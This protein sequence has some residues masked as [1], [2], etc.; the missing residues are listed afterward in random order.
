M[1]KLAVLLTL[2]TSACTSQPDYAAEH[3]AAEQQH[4]AAEQRWL[5]SPEAQRDQARKVAELWQKASDD[6]H[7]H[8]A[9]FMAQPP[10]DCNPDHLDNVLAFTGALATTTDQLSHLQ[11][12]AAWRLDAADA[13]ASH[14]CPDLAKAIYQNVIR[15]YVGSGYAA[16]RQWA[17]IGLD[18]RR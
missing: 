6:V 11:D 8:I 14:G 9:Q 15:T 16:H 10:G 2:L 3:A 4:A 13:A 17:E 1:K 12:T 5:A 18:D 7:D